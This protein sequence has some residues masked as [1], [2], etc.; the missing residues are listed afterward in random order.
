MHTL[1]HQHNTNT[2]YACDIT[3]R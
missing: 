2:S 1:I 3:N